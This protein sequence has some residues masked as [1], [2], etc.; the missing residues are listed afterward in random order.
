MLIGIYVFKRLPK[1]LLKNKTF[2][3]LKRDKGFYIF[4]VHHIR[5]LSNQYREEL[6]ILYQLKPM[7]S[8]CFKIKVF[9]RWIK[10]E[11]LES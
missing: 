10:K 2:A 1:H 4:I 7:L 11:S 5:E 3:K 9:H 8:H 6:K